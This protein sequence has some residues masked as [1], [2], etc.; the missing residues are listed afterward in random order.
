M[1]TATGA[2]TIGDRLTRL[3]VDLA[4]VRGTIERM[5]NNGQ[6]FGVN[7]S[8]VNQIAYERATQREKELSKQVRKLELRLAGVKRPNVAV[9]VMKSD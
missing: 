7:S 2:E 8:N 3:R 4:R 9:A 6:S 5:E 1:P